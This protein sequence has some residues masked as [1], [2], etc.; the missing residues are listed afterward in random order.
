MPGFHKFTHI[1]TYSRPVAVSPGD[2]QQ[3]FGV[4]GHVPSLN[5]QIE[6]TEPWYSTLEDAED[7]ASLFRG[8]NGLD[9]ED[10]Q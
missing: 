10:M 1:A 2:I 6:I 3:K 9:E 5:A 4:W 8:Y 7:Q